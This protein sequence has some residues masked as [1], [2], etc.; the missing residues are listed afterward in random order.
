ME[1]FT[2]LSFGSDGCSAQ[3]AL[4]PLPAAQAMAQLPTALRAVPFSSPAW[5]YSAVAQQL[6]ARKPEP[7]LSLADTL[8]LP[9]CLADVWD[10]AVS[11]VSYLRR[12]DVGLC[13]D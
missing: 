2:P 10:Q 5:A 11:S 9:T 13:L 6:T 12:L 1:I 4:L 3:P 8:A 7:S